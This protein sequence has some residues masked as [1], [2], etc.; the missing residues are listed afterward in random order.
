MTAYQDAGQTREAKYALAGQR[1]ERCVEKRRP[2]DQWPDRRR[3]QPCSRGQQV[4]QSETPLK[5]HPGCGKPGGQTVPWALVWQKLVRT[6]RKAREYRRMGLAGEP[7]I[8]VIGPRDLGASR[9]AG[10]DYFRECAAHNLAEAGCYLS[11]R[12]LRCHQCLKAGRVRGLL[13]RTE[14]PVRRQTFGPFW[15][16]DRPSLT[17]LLLE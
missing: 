2:R 15:N 4:N 16:Y 8:P 13:L 5:R 6:C 17:A 11:E 12:Y 10:G 1:C 14:T 7:W 3:D 9:W